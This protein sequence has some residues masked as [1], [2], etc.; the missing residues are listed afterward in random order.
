M[1]WTKPPVTILACM[2][3]AVGTIGFAYH[4]PELL[5]LHAKAF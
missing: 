2:Y 3:I 5:P 1:N 4:F